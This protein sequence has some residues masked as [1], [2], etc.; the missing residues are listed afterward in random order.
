M[1]GTGSSV[2][3]RRPAGTGPGRP[4]STGISSE[5]GTT[6]IEVAAHVLA[7]V[8]TTDRG[9]GTVVCA[10]TESRR[11]S[12]WS[13]CCWPATS[14]ATASTSTA[15]TSAAGQRR[16]GPR[17]GGAVRLDVV[18]FADRDVTEGQIVL[19]ARLPHAVIVSPTGRGAQGPRLRRNGIDID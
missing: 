13:A 17:A 8:G 6:T 11:A 5:S 14:R 1:P 12:G 16:R 18:D 4:F 7:A 3:N 19:I 2:S 10:A 15:V 9:A